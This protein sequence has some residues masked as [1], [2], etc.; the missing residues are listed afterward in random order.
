M[1]GLPVRRH[2]PRGQPVQRLSAKAGLTLVMIPVPFCQGVPH[3]QKSVRT[4]RHPAWVINIL[5]ARVCQIHEDHGFSIAAP[6]FDATQALM[7]RAAKYIMAFPWSTFNWSAESLMPSSPRT[8][9]LLRSMA[10]PPGMLRARDHDLQRI[11]IQVKM[12]CLA[13]IQPMTANCNFCLRM[14]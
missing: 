11:P 4:S 1:W 8:A 10:G 3:I 2:C 6:M 5:K 7:T 12:T 13:L 9:S 14:S